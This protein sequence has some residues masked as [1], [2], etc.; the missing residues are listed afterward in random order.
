MQ[1]IQS[2]YISLHSPY[3]FLTICFREPRT[4]WDGR[5][6][7]FQVSKHFFPIFSQL[8][9]FPLP[10]LYN[11]FSSQYTSRCCFP[12]Q[13]V[14]S[15]ALTKATRARKIHQSY[16][17]DV[18]CTVLEA[19]IEALFEVAFQTVLEVV[20]TIVL[21]AVLEPVLD[22]LLVAVLV[23]VYLRLYFFEDV[24]VAFVQVVPETVLDTVIEDVLYCRLYLRLKMMLYCTWPYL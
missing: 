8:A 21:E 14:F 10:V 7:S 17:E 1:L 16:T 2:S 12:K 6:Y 20:H 5:I 15:I 9:A 22:P 13:Y 23:D 11:T 24:Q 3:I 18:H 19:A 4:F